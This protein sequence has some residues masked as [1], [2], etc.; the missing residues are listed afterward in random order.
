M[1]WLGLGSM[2]LAQLALLLGIGLVLRWRWAR[3]TAIW[4]EMLCL[5]GSLLLIA[6]PIG[7]NRGPVA[8]LANLALPVG[9]IW[10]LRGR[11]MKAAFS[12]P[13]G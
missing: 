11:R 1:L 8:L 10:L 13:A 12:R 4:L 6:L 7:A 5:G 9:V 2:L 3:R